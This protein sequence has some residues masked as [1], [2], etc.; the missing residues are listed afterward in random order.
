MKINLEFLNVES[1]D[2]NIALRKE[3]GG[4]TLKVQ[5]ASKTSYSFPQITIKE[6]QAMQKESLLSDNQE[7]Y[8]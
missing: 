1:N 6:V 3:T 5:L 8:L 4:S 2:G 7:C